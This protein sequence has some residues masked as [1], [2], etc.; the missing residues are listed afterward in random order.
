MP[1]LSSIFFTLPYIA[2]VATLIISW[3]RLDKETSRFLFIATTCTLILHIIYAICLQRMPVPRHGRFFFID[4]YG[5]D[6]YSWA[7]ASE[8]RAGH[9]PS[10]W[11]DK[12]LGTLHTGWNRIL[13]AVY[14]VFGHKPDIPIMLN[15]LMSALLTPLCFFTAR[16]LFPQNSAT[17]N[18]K[19]VSSTPDKTVALLCAVYFSFA[20][21]AAFLMRDIFISVLFLCGLYLILILYNRWN[22]W[23]M[24]ALAACLCGLMILRIYS[25][26]AL[27]LGPAAYLLLMHREHKK[28]WLA[29]VACAAVLILAR[30]FIPMRDYQNQVI[31]TFLNNL[32]DEGKTVWGS[33]YHCARG[34]PRFF[35]APYAW[36]IS[37]RPPV[38]DYM[39]YP[40]Q[41]VL[42]LLILPYALKGLWLLIRENTVGSLF[43]IAPIIP[44]V[45]L[46]LLAYGGSVPRQRV[47]LEPLFI[48]FAAW[49]LYRKD[50][51]RG[52]PIFWYVIL[53][54]FIAAHSWS[55][56][57]R[58]LW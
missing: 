40:G 45:F 20:F 3:R 52:I 26:G 7:I 55:A 23:A 51:A 14:Y 12:Y 44:S 33:L 36:Y 22:I 41:W 31:Y 47:Y 4:E 25:V 17:H 39:L 50:K 5:Y 38:I 27:L 1:V 28:A 19:C 30:V 54:L 18:E 58:G 11:T 9:F 8:W 13:A 21:W 24:A 16:A 49:G 57:R 46:F 2:L 37:P 35:L 56:W 15:I 32:P 34:V 48:L 53:L 10:L 43:V 6:R 42:Y 29:L